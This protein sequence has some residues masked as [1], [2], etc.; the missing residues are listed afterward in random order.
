MSEA[1]QGA[2]V[3][4]DPVFT[5]GH[6]NRTW[7]EFIAVLA[8]AGVRQ[9]VDIRRYPM[10]RRHPHFCRPPMERALAEAG[11]VYRH[12][13]DLGGFRGDGAASAAMS[14]NTAWP[15]GFLR[16]YADYAQTP[17]YQQAV[18]RLRAALRPGTVL[19]CA[20]KHWRECHRQ[21]LTDYLIIA[22]HRVV[23][24]VDVQTREDGALSPH[25]RMVGSHLVYAEQRQQ[26]D[27]GF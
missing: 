20:E 3:A 22:G 18:A 15:V 4:A 8:A 7:P 11:I 24:V 17:A 5:V 2:A 12:A 21:I 13:P 16:N 9:L 1:P 14:S 10:S 6:S 25:A 26:L 19:M 27:L 23:H